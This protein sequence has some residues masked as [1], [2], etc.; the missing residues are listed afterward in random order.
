MLIFCCIFDG[1]L[2]GK[3]KVETKGDEE[4]QISDRFL[5]I[6][7]DF[8]QEWRVFREKVDKRAEE[9]EENE[10]K[11]VQLERLENGLNL[12]EVSLNDDFEDVKTAS[13]DYGNSCD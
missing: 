4:G 2:G 10:S 8:S 7:V 9:K 13:D 5:A 1:I 11:R 3:I 6:L 12:V